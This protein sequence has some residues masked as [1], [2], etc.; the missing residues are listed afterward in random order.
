ME[1]LNITSKVAQQ[2][3]AYALEFQLLAFT[4]VYAEYSFHDLL[5]D[6]VKTLWEHLKNKFYAPSEAIAAMSDINGKLNILL[7]ALKAMSFKLILFKQIQASFYLK[8]DSDLWTPSKTLKDDF[9]AFLKYCKIRGLSIGGGDLLDP[10]FLS[11]L[12]RKKHL[13]VSNNF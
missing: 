5:Y 6:T 12:M 13:K 1:K 2:L 9:L 4:H 10:E 3:Q 11:S 8:N 7:K